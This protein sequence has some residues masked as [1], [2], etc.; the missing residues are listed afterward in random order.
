MPGIIGGRLVADRATGSP[1]LFA[2]LRLT[3]AATLC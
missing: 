2:E 1:P 3:R